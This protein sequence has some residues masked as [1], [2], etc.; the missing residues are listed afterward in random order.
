MPRSTNWLPAGT[1]LMYAVQSSGCVP[2]AA[3]IVS[4]LPETSSVTGLNVWLG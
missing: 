4:P 2:G 1:L 3:M